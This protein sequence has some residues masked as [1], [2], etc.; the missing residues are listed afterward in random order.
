MIKAFPKVKTRTF[1][2]SSVV[3]SILAAATVLALLATVNSASFAASGSPHAGAV[4]ILDNAAAGNNVW[5]YPR[6]SNGH[7]G[8]GTPFATGGTG[9]GSALASQGALALSPN[10]QWL[11]AVDAGSNQITAFKVSGVSLTKTSITS[12]HG[13]DPISLT[14]WGNWLYV[15]DAGGSGNIAGFAVSSSGGLSYIAGSNKPLSGMSAPSPEQIGFNPAG[16]VLVV[17]EKGTNII[18]TYTVSSSGVASAPD[19]QASAGAGPYGFSFTTGGT[20]IVS[21]AASNSVSSYKLSSNGKLTTISGAIPDFGNAPC[22]LVVGAGNRYT[23]AANAHGGTIS[24]YKISRSG[25]LTLYSS[26]AAHTAIPTLDMAFSQNYRFLY[27]RTDTTISGF[28]VSGGSI[29][30]ITS[31]SGIP[32]SAAGLAAS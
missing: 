6:S 21:E 14:L 13:T 5:V 17:A 3:V 7:L 16:N 11:F 8:S 22:W 26:V 19:S 20:L 10:G 9:T 2:I 24:S 1:G 23:F 31:A 15:L 4:Y 32:A 12:S 25:S 18:D 29:S 27:I 30:W 28:L